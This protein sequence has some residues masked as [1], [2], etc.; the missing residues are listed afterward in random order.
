MFF[1]AVMATAAVVFVG[2]AYM[3]QV[4]SYMQQ[5]EPA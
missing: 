2:V 1:V 5:E 4:K 3:Y